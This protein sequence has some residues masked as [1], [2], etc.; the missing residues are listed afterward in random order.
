MST[1]ADVGPLEDLLA[2]ADIISAHARSSPETLRLLDHRD[3]DLLR[4]DAV[5]INTARGELI[6]EDTLTDLLRDGRI[7]GAALD[8]F[9]VEPLPDDHKLRAMPSITLSPHVA[10]LTLDARTK[11]PTLIAHRIAGFL[12]LAATSM[13][14]TGNRTG[15][16]FSEPAS[17]RRGNPARP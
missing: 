5:I 10:G 6:G 9:S 16:P 12:G 4:P 11:A 8:V 15:V 14:P 3:L 17:S 1:G 13:Q 2:E 7:G